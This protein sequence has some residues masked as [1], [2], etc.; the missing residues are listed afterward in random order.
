VRAVRLPR[1]AASRPSAATPLA[2]GSSS[3]GSSPLPAFDWGHRDA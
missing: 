1:R 3:P 2:S